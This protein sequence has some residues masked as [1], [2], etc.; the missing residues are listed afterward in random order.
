VLTVKGGAAA[1]DPNG[2]NRCVLYGG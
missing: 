1:E 2:T